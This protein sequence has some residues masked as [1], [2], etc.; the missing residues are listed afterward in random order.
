MKRQIVAPAFLPQAAL[1][2]LKEWLAI[3]T[4]RDDAALSALLRASL[5][6]CES[7]TRAMPIEALCEEVVPATRGWHSLATSPVQSITTLETI[8]ANG[9]RGAVNP[10]DYLFDILANG[11]GRVNLLRTFADVRIAVRFTAGLAPDWESLPEGLRH[12][13]IRLAAHHYRER[14]EGGSNAPP[15]AVT[16]LWQPWRGM[17]IA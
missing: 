11:S 15:A 3:T 8:A 10:G 12:G 7:F 6:T 5:D 2:E 13:I 1:N 16:A 17:V 14:N 4:T 9:T